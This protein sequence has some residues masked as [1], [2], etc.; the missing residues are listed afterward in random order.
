MGNNGR[1][2]WFSESVGIWNETE[3][4]FS[5]NHDSGNV[6]ERPLSEGACKSI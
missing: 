4:C 6:A 5:E 2:H 1:E 3:H